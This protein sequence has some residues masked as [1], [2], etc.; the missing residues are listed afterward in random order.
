MLK[1]IGKILNI[2]LKTFWAAYQIVIGVVFIAIVV[3]FLRF[4][5]YTHWSDI[6]KLST[7]NPEISAFMLAEQARIE[8]D[9]VLFERV[10]KERA[11]REA[12][13][14][15][16]Q[17]WVPYTAI[18]GLI[19]NLV[20]ISEDG[21]FFN[22][23]GFDLDQIQYAIV[24]NHQKGQK[25][26][27][28]STISQ[29]VVKNLFLYQERSY[30]RKV[31]EAIMTIFLEEYLSKERILEVYLNIAQFGPGVFGIQAGAKHH[32]GMPVEALTFPQMVS[33]VAL[34][35]KPNVWCPTCGYKGYVRHRAR[36]M[37]NLELY[38]K[39]RKTIPDDVYQSFRAFAEAA[40]AK[41]WSQLKDRADVKLKNGMAAPNDSANFR[42]GPYNPN[43]F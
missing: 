24:A 42:S 1:T 28:A 12:R 9:E 20:V 23:R 8:S 21:K 14:I 26:R 40:E 29:Q 11:R 19:K 36:I 41:R 31:R 38:K 35:P 32:F 37:R 16:W 34:L 30:S 3:C 4:A 27:G 6:R 43:H 10:K 25:W 39:I 17:E 18:P 5:Q 7:Q 2:V 22:H 33:L 15:I 13:N